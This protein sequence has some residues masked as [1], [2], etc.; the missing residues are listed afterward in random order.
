MDTGGLK[1]VKGVPTVFGLGFRVRHKGLGI[2]IKSYLL[3]CP[4]VAAVALLVMLPACFKRLHDVHLEIFPKW[5]PY[6]EDCS[7]WGSIL[8]F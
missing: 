8:G 4:Q 2:K 5:D 1:G 3:A 6:D 7:I